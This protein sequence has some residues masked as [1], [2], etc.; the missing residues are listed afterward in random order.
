MKLVFDIETNGLLD[1]LNCIHTIVI[2]YLETGETIKYR[3]VGD[4]ILEAVDNLKNALKNTTSNTIYYEII[5][6]VKYHKKR[7][8][9]EITF[10]KDGDIMRTKTIVPE[11]YE[12]V[13][14]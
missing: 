10:S 1:D 12:H 2:K 6:E 4:E 5:T 13:L 3:P 7:E 8:L 11:S 14:Y 9:L